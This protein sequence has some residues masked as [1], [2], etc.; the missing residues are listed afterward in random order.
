MG[1]AAGFGG[2]DAA[3]GFLDIEEGVVI[4]EVG[5]ELVL[6]DGLTFENMDILDDSIDEGGDV[7]VLG[8]ATCYCG[9]SIHLR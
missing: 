7:D 9:S 1:G 3:F 2:S 4:D 5:E 8:K 6:L